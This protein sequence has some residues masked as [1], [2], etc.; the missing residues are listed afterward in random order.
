MTSH[1]SLASKLQVWYRNVYIQSLSEFTVNYEDHRRDYTRD[2]LSR[3]ALAKNPMEQ[4]KNWQQD[5]IDSDLKDPTAA[6]LATVEVTGMLWQRIVLLKALTDNTF[7]FLYQLRIK[8]S[9]STS[10]Q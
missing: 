6:S 2:G 5:A 10:S 4:F 7:V 9:T 8:Q 1:R 3:K